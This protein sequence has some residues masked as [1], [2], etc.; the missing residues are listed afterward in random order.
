MLKRFRESI[1]DEQWQKCLVFARQEKK[2]FRLR[3]GGLST[4]NHDDDVIAPTLVKDTVDLTTAAGVST[5]AVTPIVSLSLSSSL[6]RNRDMIS[7]SI[8]HL[9]DPSALR[10]E[11]INKK[12]TPVP[13]SNDNI[14]HHYHNRND[15]NHNHGK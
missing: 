14:N 4:R 15:I 12:K 13:S 2:S 5:V 7:S 8:P 9:H 1:T 10:K 11:H 3:N 6:E